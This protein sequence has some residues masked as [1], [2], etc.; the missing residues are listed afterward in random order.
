ML[1]LAKM[2]K[3]ERENKHGKCFWPLLFLLAIT[4]G[5]ASTAG[6]CEPTCEGATFPDSSILQH[7]CCRLATDN[8]I[9]NEAGSENR[10][11]C[12]CRS[13]SNEKMRTAVSTDSY[14]WHPDKGNSLPLKDTFPAYT[15]AIPLLV[16][17]MTKNPVPIYLLN[18][19]LL[20]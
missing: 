9:P 17:T 10:F 7:H 19:V 15:S 11:P 3:A 8:N 4:C 18:T 16:G 5:Y 13:Q 1:T 14:R 12:T 2:N 6:A 20:I